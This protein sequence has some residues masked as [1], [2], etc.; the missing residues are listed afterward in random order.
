MVRPPPNNRVPSNTLPKRY[1]VSLDRRGS[2]RSTFMVSQRRGL[3][4]GFFA[5]NVCLLGGKA[6]L[7]KSRQ[8]AA[9]AVAAPAASST[10]NNLET[11]IAASLREGPTL[12]PSI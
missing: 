6:C 11:W 1:G 9:D 2:S 5:G 8:S 10:S 4:V 12:P 3:S 7:E